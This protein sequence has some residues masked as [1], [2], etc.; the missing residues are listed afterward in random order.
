[1][2]V[3]LRKWEFGV[4]N[5]EVESSV[6]S[7]DGNFVCN[8]AARQNYMQRKDKD[9]VSWNKYTEKMRSIK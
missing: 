8:R 9:L 1:M 2:E 6:E 4:R 3:G 7:R 5:S